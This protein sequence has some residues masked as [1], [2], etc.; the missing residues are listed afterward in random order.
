[1]KKLNGR[2]KILKS[3][4]IFTIMPGFIHEFGCASKTGCVIEEISTE[5]QRN[6]SFYLDKK[7]NQNKNRKS[8]I[9]YWLN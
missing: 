2:K 7:I 9:S 6:D 8:F 1:M 4:E 3:G 5:S